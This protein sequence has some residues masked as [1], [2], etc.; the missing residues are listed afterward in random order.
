VRRRLGGRG[1]LSEI[2]HIAKFTERIFSN[3]A[4]FVLGFE[5]IDQ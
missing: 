1:D 5:E 3:Y 4:H 2:W